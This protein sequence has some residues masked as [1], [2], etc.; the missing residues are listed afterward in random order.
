[1]FAVMIDALVKQ[2]TSNTQ[3]DEQR[4]QVQKTVSLVMPVS[5][6]S[7]WQSFLFS[8]HAF[9]VAVVPR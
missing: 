7:R 5:P 4:Q 9:V 8:Q 1:M 3:N 6:Q 2:N